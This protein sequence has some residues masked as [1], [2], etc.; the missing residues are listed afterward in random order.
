MVRQHVH[1]RQACLA[2]CRQS[3]KLRDD[4][5]W[6]GALAAVVNVG[7]MLQQL[8][9]GFEMPCRPNALLLMRK[10]SAIRTKSTTKQ[11]VD[12]REF[13]SEVEPCC[14][15][16][17]MCQCTVVP[18][19]LNVRTHTLKLAHIRV[20]EPVQEVVAISTI[21]LPSWPSTK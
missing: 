20:A 6:E 10:H 21:V 4:V 1:S 5:L 13:G 19:P 7:S 11:T 14:S 16:S 8:A 3:R 2:E 18:A 12:R 15:V 17:A 9:C